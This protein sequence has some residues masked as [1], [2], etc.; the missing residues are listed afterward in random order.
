MVE[1][2]ST[3]EISIEAVKIFVEELTK[4]KH[5]IIK[6]KRTTTRYIIPASL[7][8]QVAVETFRNKIFAVYDTNGRDITPFIRVTCFSSDVN[9]K[10]NY[11]VMG[12][13]NGTLTITG[14]GYLQEPQVLRLLE[15]ER[16]LQS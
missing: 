6:D 1:Y 12:I 15:I 9:E 16:S 3:T 4:E 14:F 13:F 8:V 11:L 7:P 10:G 5:K 2:H